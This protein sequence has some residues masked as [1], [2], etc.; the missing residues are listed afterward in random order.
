MCRTQASYDRYVR[1]IAQF[2]RITPERE[3]ELSRIIRKS[4]N[5]EMVETAVDE[6]IHANLFLVIHCLKDFEKFLSFPGIHITRMDLI[7]EGNIALMTAARRYSA[8]YVSLASGKSVKFSTYACGI[9]R[10]RMRRALKMARLI[11]VPEQ[12]FAYW[13]RMRKLEE[14][15]GEDLSDEFLMDKLGVGASKLRKLRRSFESRISMLEDMAVEDGESRWTDVIPNTSV[16]SPGYE[17]DC[18]DLNHFLQTELDRLPER[19]QKMI[20]LAFLSE[21]GASLSDLSEQFG[22]SRE[23]CRQVLA[24]GLK[25]LRGRIE[26]QWDRAVNPDEYLTFSTSAYAAAMS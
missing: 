2:S 21:K 16:V 13:S 8:E 11:H 1:E 5:H 22:V 25:I 6:M 10:N 3:A 17:A 7:A 9:I 20:S 15:F 14:E 26:G 19:T 4:R 24:K 12:H 18:R 23:R